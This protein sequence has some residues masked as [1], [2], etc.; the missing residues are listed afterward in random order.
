MNEIIDTLLVWDMGLFLLGCVAVAVWKEFL[1]QY[2]L[3]R[4]E[5]EWQEK[6]RKKAEEESK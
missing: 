6:Q 4:A 5:K 3:W 2:D 1:Y